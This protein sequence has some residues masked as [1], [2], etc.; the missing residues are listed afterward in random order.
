MKAKPKLGP[1]QNKTKWRDFFDS[2]YLASWDIDADTVVTFTA[3]KYEEVT[4]EKGRKD[5]C[6]VAYFKEF[7]KGMILNVTNSKTISTIHESIY[8]IDWIGKQITLYVDHNVQMK[9]ET[10]SGLRVRPVLPVKPRIGAD[11][12]AKMV[13]AIKANKYDKVMAYESFE[14]SEEQ[15]NT[16]AAL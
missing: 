16:L 9:G 12:F 2:D 15:K 10:T 3:F 14:L 6:L 13:D 11:R 4:G 7:D 5:K 8:P 1:V